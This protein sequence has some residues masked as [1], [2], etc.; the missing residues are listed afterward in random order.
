MYG[1]EVYKGHLLKKQEAVRKLK[2]KKGDEAHFSI[3][4]QVLIK[5]V[6]EL[7]RQ[8][9]KMESALLGPLVLLSMRGKLALL[10][11]LDA[12]TPKK[13]I[14]LLTLIEPEERFPAKLKKVGTGFP[15]TTTIQP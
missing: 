4:D 6:K 8:G 5:N 2:L 7:Q 11:S 1:E 10:A 12:P 13:N 14:D 15:L 9:G 3:G